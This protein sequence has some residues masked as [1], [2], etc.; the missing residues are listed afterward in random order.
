MSKHGKRI[1]GKVRKKQQQ[2]LAAKASMQWKERTII[3]AQVMTAVS[4]VLMREFSLTQDDC[5]V[6]AE[7]VSAQINANNEKKEGG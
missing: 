3:I 4:Q 5:V 1:A 6:F 7:K 2:Q